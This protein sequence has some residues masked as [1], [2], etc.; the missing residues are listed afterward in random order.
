MLYWPNLNRIQSQIAIVIANKT[1]PKTRV[2]MICL[3][4]KLSTNGITPIN[5]WPPLQFV[6][7][8]AIRGQNLPFFVPSS[9]ND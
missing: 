8:R 6:L 1:D 5:P 2:A 3:A 9:F 4:H 7:I